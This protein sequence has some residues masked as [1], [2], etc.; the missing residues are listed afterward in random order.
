MM[1]LSELRELWCPDGDEKEASPCPEFSKFLYFLFAPTL[2][3]RDHYPRTEFSTLSE[4]DNNTVTKTS[5][6]IY[7]KYNIT[8]LMIIYVDG[9]RTEQVRWKFVVS[10]FLQVVL[11]LFYL[12][13][14]FQRTLVPLFSDFGL[15]PLTSKSFMLLVFNCIFPAALIYLIGFFAIL[16]SWFN[17]FAE[18]LRFADR[19]FYQDWWNM[20][21]YPEYYRT[22]NI[23]V[24]E[25]LYFY[26]YRDF[27][28]VFGSKRMAMH[29]VFFISAVV[30]EYILAFSFKF[31]YPVLYVLFAIM[32]SEFSTSL[33]GPLSPV[34][35][36]MFIFV[37]EKG[38]KTRG[39]NVFMWLTFFLGNALMCCLYCME[40]FAR[41]NCQPLAVS[42]SNIGAAQKPLY[43]FLV[44]SE[45]G[46]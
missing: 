9:V 19:E 41:L 18:M 38:N 29:M 20:T 39:W 44:V 10:N 26:V 21:S 32:G 34:L 45:F 27:T 36:A 17:A 22:W 6:T 7:L 3:Y 12:Y 13:F 8:R 4:D 37:T 11:G 30:H 43:L 23:V 5:R 40:W 16:H 15:A 2:L 33:T 14:I 42:L 25:W 1:N 31:F 28:K 24:H 35:A 46:K